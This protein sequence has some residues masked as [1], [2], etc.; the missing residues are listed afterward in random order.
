MTGDQHRP[1]DG[2]GR[3][4]VLASAQTAR[5]WSRR[6]FLG[7]L[8]AAALTAC[9]SGPGAAPESSGLFLSGRSLAVA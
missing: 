8:T 6:G 4:R 3:L 7:A 5:S 9:A 1:H 2:T